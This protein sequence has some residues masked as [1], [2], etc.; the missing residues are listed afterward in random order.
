MGPEP[1]QRTWTIYVCPC[2]SG[3]IAEQE[4]SCGNHPT[5]EE[6]DRYGSGAYQPEQERIE[7]VPASV[8]EERDRELEVER[9][10][11]NGV[12]SH[13]G[14][15]AKCARES[16]LEAEQLRSQLTQLADFIEENVPG[17][18][19]LRDGQWAVVT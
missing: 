17:A 10:R 19:V 14:Y 8:L 7:V 18:E 3:M 15:W 5:P 6:W 1:T 9:R 16:A 13:A 4:F 12:A 2:G 11:S